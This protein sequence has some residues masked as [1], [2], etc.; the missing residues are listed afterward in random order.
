MSTITRRVQTTEKF[1]ECEQS[2]TVVVGE[3]EYYLHQVPA[4]VIT[5]Q[6]SRPLD[7]LFS[8]LKGDLRPCTVTDWSEDQLNKEDLDSISAKYALHDDVW[9]PAFLEGENSYRR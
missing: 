9:T 7:G 4:H 5:F 3:I 6:P 2:T 8:G 1:R